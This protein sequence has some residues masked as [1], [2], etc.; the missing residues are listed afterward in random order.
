M[1]HILFLEMTGINKSYHLKAYEIIL[2]AVERVTLTFLHAFRMCALPLTSWAYKI[3]IRM[4]HYQIYARKSNV[5]KPCRSA[6]LLRYYRISRKRTI[7][8]CRLRLVSFSLI[9]AGRRGRGRGTLLRYLINV[10]MLQLS[11]YCTYELGRIC[12]IL[13]SFTY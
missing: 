2:T 5:E 3:C 12:C 8:P 9:Y 4:D 1:E 7:Q 10:I 13:W 11:K 6:G